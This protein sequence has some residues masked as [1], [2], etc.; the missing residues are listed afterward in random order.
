M[1]IKFPTVVSLL[2]LSL[3]LMFFQFNQSI[4]FALCLYRI[5]LDYRT[6]DNDVNDFSIHDHESFF[7]FPFLN[8]CTYF[9]SN[10]YLFDSSLC[11]CIN[12][13]KHTESNVKNLVHIE[14]HTIS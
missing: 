10:L 5:L 11:I 1:A 9:V 14:K 2:F 4:V 12:L 7:I 8:V 3:Q 13:N 6:N